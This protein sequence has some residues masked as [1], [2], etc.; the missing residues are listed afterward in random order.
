MTPISAIILAGGR[1]TR[2]NGIDKGLALLNSTPLIQHVI[3][4]LAPQVD[5]IIINANRELSLYA[6]LGYPVLADQ[7]PGFVGPLAGIS[8]G[9]QHAKHD[10]LLT[11]PCDSPLLPMDLA[12]RLL[13]ALNT[14]HADIAVASCHGH[15]HPV[16]CLCKKTALPA[17][18]AYLNQGE[19]RVSHWQK[20]LSYAEVDFSDCEQAFINLNT[21]DDLAAL[22][23][24]LAN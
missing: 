15:S 2:M 22:E 11:V 5:E 20:S 24:Q 14:H 4:R 21:L 23:S 1:A 12:A 16:F 19:R 13:A 9:L 7:Y 18:S 8:L 3:K 10:Y 17:L 6:A